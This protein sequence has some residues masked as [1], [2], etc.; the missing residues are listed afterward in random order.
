MYLSTGQGGA[1]YGADANHTLSSGA[2]RD[3]VGCKR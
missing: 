3:T 1:G 2:N